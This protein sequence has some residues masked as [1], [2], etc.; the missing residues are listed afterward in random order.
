MTKVAS[1]PGSRVV[2][3]AMVG[4]PSIQDVIGIF[5][6]PYSRGYLLDGHRFFN[7]LWQESMAP[8]AVFSSVSRRLFLRTSTN[9][10]IQCSLN[11]L[12]SDSCELYRVFLELGLQP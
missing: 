7:D 8:L 5:K 12:A 3:Q 4:D 11:A 9:E 6:D 10:Q 2:G 1:Y